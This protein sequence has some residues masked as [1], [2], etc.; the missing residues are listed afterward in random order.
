M[1]GD[2]RNRKA[3]PLD[4]AAQKTVRFTK[5]QQGIDGFARH[6]PVVRSS[7]PNVG[8]AEVSHGAIEGARCQAL[9]HA[10][11]LIL[12]ANRQDN[13]KTFAPFTKQLAHERRRMLQV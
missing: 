13:V 1:K 9:E 11:A 10:Q 8:V 6:Q 7:Q 2:L 4:H 5:L 3:Q 12:L